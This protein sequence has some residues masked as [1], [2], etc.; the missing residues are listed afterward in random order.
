M[1]KVLI[2]CGGL[3]VVG[4]LAIFALGYMIL[5]T[6][7]SVEHSIV[8]NAPPEDV[9]AVLTDLRTWEEW[10]WWN[11][12]RDPSCDWDYTGEP[13]TGMKMEWI[14]DTFGHGTLT[15]TQ[16]DPAKGFSYAMEFLDYDSTAAGEFD[17][18]AEGGGTRI[19]WSS[20]GTTE[21]MFLPGLMAFAMPK[22]L[23]PAFTEGLDGLKAR[24]EGGS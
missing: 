22:M 15:I 16:A 23:A 21:G 18:A 19:T 24:V 5:G 10:S 6:E 3:V 11:K 17:Y 7:W 4:I 20:N 12:E 13:G 1:K 9:H 2:G 14:G 8:V